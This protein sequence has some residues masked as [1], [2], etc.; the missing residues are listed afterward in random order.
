[1]VFDVTYHG[2]HTCQQKTTKP[3]SNLLI[4]K[5]KPDQVRD[6]DSKPIKPFQP[7]VKL[8]TEEGFYSGLMQLPVPSFLSGFSETNFLS[9]SDVGEYG[10]FHEWI[11]MAGY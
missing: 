8:K 10:D 11:P 5:Q 6:Q 4:A 7:E 9:L 1:M 2:T 3:N